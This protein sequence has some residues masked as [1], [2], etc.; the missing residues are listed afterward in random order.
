VTLTRELCARISDIGYRALGTDCVQRVKQLV[1]DGVAVAAAGS[2][3]VPVRLLAAHLK[4]LGGVP[5]ATLWGQGFRSSPLHAA[6]AN[7]MATHVLDFE[8]MSQ[9]PTHVVS[10]TVPVA[11][12]LAEARGA[13]GR[14]VIAAV[15]KGIE[16]QG[17]IQFAADEFEPERLRF[18]PPGVAGVMGA[19]VTAAHLLKLDTVRLAHALGIAAS[20]AGALLANVGSMT[21][22]THCGHAAACGLEAALLAS[23]GFTANPDIFDA[24][25]GFI[26]TYFPQ[27]FH[28][29]R[30]LAFG[31]PYRL[32]NP[33]LAIKLFPSQFAT[34]WAITAALDLRRQIADPR[35]IA[36]LII[37]AP[38]ME[39]IDRPQ[40]ATGLDGKFSLQYTAAVAL[41]DGRVTIDSFTDARRFRADMVDLLPKIELV[42][43]AAIPGD[44][45]GMRIELR[46]ELVAGQTCEA[47]CRGPRGAWGR[48][49]LTPLEHEAKLHD[50]LSRLLDRRQSK[51]L[52]ER[53][54]RL[55]RLDAREVRRIPATLAGMT[56]RRARGP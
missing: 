32:V 37:R 53:I 47:V 27:T 46:A 54:D 29:R 44:W 1:K 56:R 39:Y 35:L 31:K 28:R 17:R 13:C 21:K 48:A 20:R 6:L 55:E 9:P 2:S 26:A 19:T 18:H 5:R 3:E 34:H 16:L 52:L 8:P 51:R 12:A 49:P 33:G 25:R 15:A 40:P 10:T 24:P 22:S 23:R 11:F 7:G 50:C 14:E 36:R 41:L 42:Q 30:L 38:R 43:D 4:E 45:A